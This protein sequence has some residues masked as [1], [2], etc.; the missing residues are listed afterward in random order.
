MPP[1]HD[2][3][4]AFADVVARELED[5]AAGH[6]PSCRQA[7]KRPSISAMA[8]SKRRVFTPCAVTTVGRASVW[9]PE[10]SR[11]H[12]MT[13]LPPPDGR[14]AG[15]GRAC[16][17]P[18]ITFRPEAPAGCLSCR[19]ITA[20]WEAC[21]ISVSSRFRV[22][23]VSERDPRRSMTRKRIRARTRRDPDPRSATA[24]SNAVTWGQSSGRINRFPGG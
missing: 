24:L 22:A 12:P 8:A 21:Q 7:V 5:N 6:A 9:A 11:P 20:A 17:A 23:L 10:P 13:K 14:R 2:T 16:C 4:G 18:S 1:G 3:A 15:R 19:E